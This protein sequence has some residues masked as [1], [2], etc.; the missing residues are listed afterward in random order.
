MVRILIPLLLTLGF[1][2]VATDAMPSW[3]RLG[4]MV[5]SDQTNVYSKVKPWNESA[6]KYRKAH[7]SDSTI[8]S[9]TFVSQRKA[10][11]DQTTLTGKASTANP[12]IQPLTDAVI[13]NAATLKDGQNIEIGLGLDRIY[14]FLREPAKKIPVDLQNY[15]YK[16]RI[17]G[18]LRYQ[19]KLSQRVVELGKY[20]KDGGGVNVA[21]T[22]GGISDDEDEEQSLANFRLEPSTHELRATIDS[23][24]LKLVTGGQQLNGGKQVTL[25]SPIDEPLT[26]ENSQDEYFPLR[27][28]NK[29]E[30]MPITIGRWVTPS[31]LSLL[32]SLVKNAISETEGSIPVA[33]Q[34]PFLQPSLAYPQ[35]VISDGSKVSVLP[36]S[37]LIPKD[38]KFT[39]TTKE[40]QNAYLKNGLTTLAALVGE[41]TRSLAEASQKCGFVHI[42]RNGALLSRDEI[43][44][45]WNPD[46]LSVDQTSFGKKGGAKVNRDLM[47]VAS[48]LSIYY[49]DDFANS[50]SLM[51]V[52]PV[53]SN[54]NLNSVLKEFKDRA[55]LLCD[56]PKSLLG[57]SLWIEYLTSYHKILQSFPDVKTRFEDGVANMADV[58][59]VTWL[60][61]PFTKTNPN[62]YEGSYY[63][64][65]SDTLPDNRGTTRSTE[66]KF[67][68][69]II[70]WQT[71]ING[72]S[73]KYISRDISRAEYSSR[74]GQTYTVDFSHVGRMLV[75]GGFIFDRDSDRDVVKSRLCSASE[76]WGSFNES[77]VG[78]IFNRKRLLSRFVSDWSKKF[79]DSKLKCQIT[80]LGFDSFLDCGYAVQLFFEPVSSNFLS[81]ETRVPDWPRFIPWD[82]WYNLG[83][84]SS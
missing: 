65:E 83:K 66:L 40:Q 50:L 19:C 55:L 48:L 23:N 8:K 34:N 70:S 62:Y 56:E 37:M 43:M 71:A 36:V 60:K 2:Q 13:I 80:T 58:F 41:T 64:H 3:A 57:I 73:F 24:K 72:A 68:R 30:K 11:K 59:G 33:I 49:K 28:S 79:V 74:R 67:N 31:D 22:F 26:L 20:V 52:N 69:P 75:T 84:G 76:T 25:F 7:N 39:F 35:C 9:Q 61:R 14:L 63:L 4:G 82:V 1:T 38:T 29:L 10:D 5:S 51:K 18:K 54:R 78:V 45:F 81:E 17:N 42:E 47:Q 6:T 53:W 21:A 77:P 16:I 15:R 27:S 32:E 46:I 44:E 12:K